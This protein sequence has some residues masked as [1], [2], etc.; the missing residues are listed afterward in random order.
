MNN[1]LKLSFLGAMI[2]LVAGCSFTTAAFG[3]ITLGTGWDDSGKAITGAAT[4]FATSAAAIHASVEVKS[5]PEKTKVAVEWLYV[6]GDTTTKIT[7]NETVIEDGGSGRLHFYV[8]APYA[9]WPAGNYTFK[10]TLYDSSDAL[11]TVK[12]TSF[13]VQ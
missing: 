7:S 11:V 13:T 4:S 5:V 8:T 6:E 10:S 9:G 3:D 1:V 12:E 2:T